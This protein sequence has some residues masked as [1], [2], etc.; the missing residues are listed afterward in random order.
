ME[1]QFDITPMLFFLSY[2]QAQIYPYID[3]VVLGFFS[4]CENWGKLHTPFM[5]GNSVSPFI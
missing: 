2:R 4:T 1:S 3:V 5:N